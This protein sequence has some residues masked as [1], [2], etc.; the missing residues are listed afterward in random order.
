MMH[1]G[2]TADEDDD[3]LARRLARFIF[4]KVGDD[5]MHRSIA[6]KVGTALVESRC[7]RVELDELLEAVEAKR[8]SGELDCSGAYFVTSIKRIFQREE[9]P[10]RKRKRLD[11]TAPQ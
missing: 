1:E 7:S 5:R 3:V 10:W 2:V 11:P 8:L 4:H 9:I 6:F